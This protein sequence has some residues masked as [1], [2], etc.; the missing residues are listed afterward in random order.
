MALSGKGLPAEGYLQFP[1]IYSKKGKKETNT[2]ASK[3]VR[4][5]FIESKNQTYS[6]RQF[7][8]E[9]GGKE[10]AADE[11]E[12]LIYWSDNL[13]V[14]NFS[15]LA[16]MYIDEKRKNGKQNTYYNNFTNFKD[17]LINTLV[18]TPVSWTA[19]EIANLYLK[20][21]NLK[22]NKALHQ[23]VSRIIGYLQGLSST[24]SNLRNEA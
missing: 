7:F 11:Q 18:E 6:L 14:K 20:R 9:Q 23:S 3:I 5:E 24:L 22:F 19:D 1:Q 8:Q 12:M 15:I 17:Y 10:R 2:N 21:R 4:D 16:R 13:T